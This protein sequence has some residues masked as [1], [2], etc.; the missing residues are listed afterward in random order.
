M[1]LNLQIAPGIN[2]GGGIFLGEGRRGSDISSSQKE[3]HE[4]QPLNKM[5][6]IYKL[7]E[8]ADSCRTL[9]LTLHFV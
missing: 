6:M 1:S 5:N 8:A 9:L 3:S 2:K 7:Y 4:Y